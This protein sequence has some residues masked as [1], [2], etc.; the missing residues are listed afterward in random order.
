MQ[1]SERER[2]RARESEE[3]WEDERCTARS[4][5]SRWAKVKRTRAELQGEGRVWTC[6]LYTSDAADDM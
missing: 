4:L 3:D 2:E 6:L 1:K 5:T